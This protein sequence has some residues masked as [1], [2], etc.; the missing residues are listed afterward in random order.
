MLTKSKSKVQGDVLKYLVLSTTQSYSVCCHR[1]LK[2]AE[3]I[4]IWEAEI[5]EF[6][7][8]FLKNNKMIN[9]LSEEL[10][11]SLIADN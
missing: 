1:G 10:A 5:R 6:W 2:K 7:H 4:H 3:N 8:F 9:R 11:I